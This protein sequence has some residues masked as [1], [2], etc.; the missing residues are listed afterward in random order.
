[1]QSMFRWFAE[2]SAYHA[3]LAQVKSLDP[4]V[5]NLAAWLKTVDY[6]PGA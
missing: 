2:T 6:Q 3:D 1:M 5:L 4:E